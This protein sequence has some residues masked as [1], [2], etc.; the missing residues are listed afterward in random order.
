MKTTTHFA[1]LADGTE[2]PGDF[3]TV[4]FNDDEVNSSKNK[5]ELAKN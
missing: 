4:E 3:A 5:I 2:N 1:L